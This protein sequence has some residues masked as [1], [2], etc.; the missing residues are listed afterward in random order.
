MLSSPPLFSSV[1]NPLILLVGLNPCW[2]Q[3][4]LELLSL[5][6]N[7]IVAACPCY[8]GCCCHNFL[9]PV[10]ATFHCRVA[11]CHCRRGCHNFFRS[12]LPGVDETIVLAVNLDKNKRMNGATGWTSPN[13]LLPSWLTNRWNI[14]TVLKLA[15]TGNLERFSCD[16]VDRKLRQFVYSWRVGGSRRVSLSVMS[17]ECLQRSIAKA[18]KRD[19]SA[20]S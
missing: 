12:W 19:P 17:V 15:S 10:I 9:R 13:S 1:L 8:R 6:S 14:S 4:L 5:S 16:Y 11:A 18:T 20:T 3:S 2:F 7:N